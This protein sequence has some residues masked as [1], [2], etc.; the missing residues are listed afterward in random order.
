MAKEDEEGRL[1]R[2][3]RVLLAREPTTARS[4]HEWPVAAHDL[5]KRRFIAVGEETVEQQAIVSDTNA[6]ELV[7]QAGQHSAQANIMSR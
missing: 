5:R 6:V 2:I 1:E 7:E 3:L 4:Q